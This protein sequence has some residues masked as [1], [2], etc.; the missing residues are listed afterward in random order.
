MKKNIFCAI[1]VVLAGLSLASCSGPAKMAKNPELVTVSCNPQVLEVVADVIN[2]T[3]TVTF[4]E[5]YFHPKAILEIVPVLTYKDGE[6][7]APIMNL[8]GEKILDNHTVIPLSGGGASHQIQFAFKKGMEVSQLD[9]ILTVM[10][11]KGNRYPYPYAYKVADGT[12]T[13]YK[14]A[15][16]NGYTTF[17][18]DSYQEV[19]REQKETQIMYLVNSSEVRSKELTK[20]E[21]KE[22]E[23]FLAN[24]MKDERREVKNTEIIAYASPEGPLALNNK[25][26]ANR[27]KSAETAYK[28]AT[29]KI[30]AGV[31]LKTLSM[32]EDW[33]GFKKLVS[34]SNVEDKDL[35]L[36]VLEMY[37]DS[38][39]RDRE[40]R[41]MSKVFTT[42][43]NKVLPELRRARWI[44]NVD[45]TNYTPNELLD[46]VNNQIDLLDEEALLRVGTLLT[47]NN[48]KITAYK[49]A[50]EKFNS[51]RG[52]NNLAVCYLNGGDVAAAKSA[53][54]KA[55]DQDAYV[56]N[57]QAV[58]A[59][60]EGKFDEAYAL[61]G[62]TGLAES[63]HSQGAIDIMKGK[64]ADAATKLAGE[65]EHNQAIAYIMTGQ[66]D[67]AAE[68]VKC[69]C[70]RGSYI[71]AIIAA[72]KGDK[73]AWDKEMEVVNANASFK[74]RAENDIEFAKMR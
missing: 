29:K 5:R 33:E 16:F 46:M 35:I 25:L 69:E 15:T 41:N 72:R 68:I 54:A 24:A 7:K 64:Y 19:I 1:V 34:S 9:L 55:S 20:G 70:P 47:N 49:Q 32:G 10:D 48:D 26:S 17:A 39:V 30:A 42:L 38:N 28:N 2:V 59:L 60:R 37:G 6:E 4:A 74:A 73:A 56:K 18:P 71:R 36:R 44:A 45:F 21:I 23:Q 31:D 12:I 67:K 53:L 43:Q 61:F 51:S 40:I 13:T 14:L 66:L 52:Y 3:Y 8:Q 11:K 27:E 58:I 62:Q 57:N 63:K 22:F 50:A 65:G